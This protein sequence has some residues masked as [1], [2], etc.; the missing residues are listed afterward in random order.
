M[1]ATK[2]SLPTPPP[3][4]TSIPSKT[5]ITS[6][7]YTAKA[8]GD[9]ITLSGTDIHWA[10]AQIVVPGETNKLPDQW[11]SNLVAVHWNYLGSCKKY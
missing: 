1:D 6:I 7:V 8:L 11:L 5:T 10:G 2:L 4:Q 3:R 9:L